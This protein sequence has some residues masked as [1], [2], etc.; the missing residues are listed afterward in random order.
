MLRRLTLAGSLYLGAIALLAFC[1]LP[2]LWM[3]YSAFKPAG[4]LFSYPPR[5][6]GAYDL[7]NFR[8]LLYETDFPVYLRNSVGIA[9]VTVAINIVISTLGAYSLTRYRFPG[10]ELLANLTLFTYMFAPIMLIIP[11]YLLLTKL[12]LANTHLGIV[13]AYL[14]I[15][16]PFTLWLLRAFFQSLPIDLEHAAWVD[17]ATRLQA[18]VHVVVP[19]ALPGVIATSVFAFVVVWNDYLFA[20]VLLN[21]RY[22]LTMPVGLQDMYESTIVDWGLLM[23]GAVVVTIPAILFFLVVQRFLIEGWG[24]GAVKG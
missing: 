7:A 24:M 5:V 9:A 11:V 10:K 2:L 4:E 19:Q 12:G 21:E 18:V 16:L 13:L 23:S 14:S 1:G 8:K 15:S 20:R 22:L 6:L 17:G 3:L